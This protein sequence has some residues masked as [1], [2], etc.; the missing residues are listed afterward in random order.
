MDPADFYTNIS[1]D[2]D[3]CWNWTRARRRKR[4]GYGVVSLFGQQI[5]AHRA[6]YELSKGPIP[7]GKFVCHSC[8]NPACVNPSHLWVGT[9]DENM[10]DAASKG[11]RKAPPVMRGDANPSRKYPEKRKR[12]ERHPRSFLTSETIIDIRR[13]YIAGESRR[14]MAERFNVKMS[15]LDDVVYGRVWKHLF[16]VDGAPTLE[17]L[18]AA[19]RVHRP[20]S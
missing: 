19:K 18:K 3:G 9:H 5:L 10:A 2:E 20:A 7:K 11:R 1:V 8:D 15:F 12:G 13:A 6:S 16:G 17:D 4:G 14:A